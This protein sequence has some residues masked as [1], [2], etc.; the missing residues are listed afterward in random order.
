MAVQ[1]DDDTL[2][3]WRKDDTVD[4]FS[5]ADWLRSA[6]ADMLDIYCTTSDDTWVPTSTKTGKC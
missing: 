4:M 5:H 6:Y 3:L 2:A 1:W